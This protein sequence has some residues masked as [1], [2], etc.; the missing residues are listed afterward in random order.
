MLEREKCLSAK[1]TQVP[2]SPVDSDMRGRR[3]L[4]GTLIAGLFIQVS[5]SGQLRV[6]VPAPE[7]SDS[8]SALWLTS[9]NAHQPF[10]LSLFK[11]FLWTHLP[12]PPLN[13]NALFSA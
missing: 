6:S 9:V 12:Q 3:R 13:I 8:A 4:T 5:A 11:F 7:D 10:T 2:P 1:S